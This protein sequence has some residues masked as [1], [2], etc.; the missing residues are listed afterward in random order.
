MVGTVRM[1]GTVETVGMVG[2]AAVPRSSDLT[3][4]PTLTVLTVPTVPTILTILTV[5]SFGRPS[6]YA[7]SATLPSSPD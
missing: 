2:R 7:P 4:P 1:V 6:P 3:D 5:P